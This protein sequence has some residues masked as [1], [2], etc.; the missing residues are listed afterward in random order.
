MGHTVIEEA[1]A[2][3]EMPEERVV[4]QPAEPAAPT[5]EGEDDGEEAGHAR[6][7][8]L[9]A[10]LRHCREITARL[11]PVTGTTYANVTLLGP[12][13]DEIVAVLGDSPALVSE[14]IGGM[15]V[16]FAAADEEAHQFGE[17]I[18]AARL[19]AAG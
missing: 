10:G 16:V 8:R 6:P 1:P 17:G 7:H 2:R 4:G 19:S 3:A 9:A 15:T 14:T 12:A 11:R 5:A 18:T 13:Q